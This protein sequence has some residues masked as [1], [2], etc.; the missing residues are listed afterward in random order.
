MGGPYRFGQRVLFPETGRGR[1][2]T[3]VSPSVHPVSDRGA[4]SHVTV[5]LCDDTCD[6]RGEDC[7]V[8]GGG[9]GF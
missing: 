7:L 8:L 3:R 6:C 5:R 9:H 4:W 1:M 2:G